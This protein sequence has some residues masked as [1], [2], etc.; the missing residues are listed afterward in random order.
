M[1]G[2]SEG[3][4]TTLRPQSLTVLP[5]PDAEPSAG[6]QPGRLCAPTIFSN[7]PPVP[8]WTA[9]SGVSDATRRILRLLASEFARLSLAVRDCI[10]RERARQKAF[11]EQN[12]IPKAA[13]LPYEPQ[14]LTDVEKAALDISV[15]DIRDLFGDIPADYAHEKFLQAVSTGDLR[16]F[17]IRLLFLKVRDSLKGSLL[18]KPFLEGLEES[19]SLSE[20]MAGCKPDNS[21]RRLSKAEQE[22][23]IAD[24]KAAIASDKKA[25]MDDVRAQVVDL[26][27][28]AAG[29]IIGQKLG[30]DED[31]KLAGEIVDS[32]M[33]K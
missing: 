14:S 7:E 10:G 11:R 1:P 21:P 17:K 4:S 6:I 5:A 13:K 25:A 18:Y 33:S 12:G 8:A 27:M 22:R 30:T 23:I 2:G 29:K 28:A 15:S 32:V 19:I 24:A 31:K 9:T 20:N 3:T 26:A 16:A